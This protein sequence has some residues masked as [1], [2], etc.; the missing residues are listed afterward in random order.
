ML[1]NKITLIISL[2]I[3]IPFYMYSQNLRSIKGYIKNEKGNPIA[4][5]SVNAKKAG[6]I[7]ISDNN[8]NF[9]IDV[10]PTDSILFTHI[11]YIP[12]TLTVS[13]N[14]PSIL[15]IK[16]QEKVTGLE[17]VIINTG[18]QSI[19]KDRA[20]GSFYNIDNKI[21]N[22]QVTTNILDHLDGI[23][24]G[25]LVDKRNIGNDG[26]RYQ[27]RGLSTLT[28][29]IQSPLIVL[30]NFP[31]EG[32]LKN[33]NPND[34]ESVTILKDAAAS[35]IWGAR[36]GNGVIVITTKK[37]RK[38]APLQIS[39]N[40]NITIVSKPNLLNAPQIPVKDFIGL[41]EY[42]YNQEFYDWRF[43]D[44]WRTPLPAVAEILNLKKLALISENAADRQLDSLTDNDVRRDMEQYLYRNEVRSQTA[45]NLRGGEGNMR[46]LFSAGYD[47]NLYTLRGNRDER[48]TFRTDNTLDITKK[49]QLNTGII[50]TRSESKTNSP[51]GYGG[52]LGSAEMIAPYSRLANETGKPMA[53]DLYYRGL[54]TDTAGEGKL[55][56]WKYRPLQQLALNDISSK[57]SDI[58]I[59]IGSDYKIA[60]WLIVNIKYQYQQSNQK[61]PWYSSVNDFYTRDLINTFTQI[62]DN[63]ISY[64][65]PV[66]GTL[67]TIED[68][69][70]AQSVRGQL[71]FLH[72]WKNK[73]EVSAI[74]G[75][76][77]RSSKTDHAAGTI[78]GVNSQTLTTQG[79]D[80]VNP[81]YTYNGI[82]DESYIP[83]GTQLNKYNSRFVS[84]YGNASY[85][86]NNR[87]SLYGS[88][89]RDA[90]NIFGVSI[91]QK[92]Q[93]LWAV[94]GLWNLSKER[95][96]KA[97][98]FPIVNLRLSY[99][100]S[101]NLDPTTSALLQI[102]YIDPSSSLYRLQSARI[103]SPQN[104]LLRWEK[105]KTLNTGIDFS[106]KNNRLSGS[107]EYYK[108]HSIDLVSTVTLDPTTGFTYMRLNSA[109][110]KGNGVDI[111]LNSVNI[112]KSIKWNTTLLFSYT[113]FIV[114]NY[115][116]D[117]DESQLVTKGGLFPI[118]GYNP[119]SIIAY[120][121]AGLNP[122]SGDPQGYVD[123][124]VSSDYRI[125]LASD[126][127][128][129]V[130]YKTA[131]PPYYGSLRNIVE[132]KGFTLTFNISYKLGH[133]LL[134]P[135]LNYTTLF[136]S[137]NGAD[138]NSE[139]LNRWQ[140]RGDE[141]KTH[142]P[143]LI[144]PANS[145]RDNFYNGSSVNVINAG[146]IRLQ[147]I[148]LSY[149]YVP[150]RRQAFTSGQL[151]LFANQLNCL[152]WKANKEGLDP[153]ML[154]GIKPSINIS[155]GV[156]LNF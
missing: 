74:G 152:L 135:S 109:S 95:F 43:D 123:G 30:D 16:M 9:E 90:S 18:Y 104:D 38:N 84:I 68:T 44:V 100:L 153:E 139:Y 73:H 72:L 128:N 82:R 29:A 57:V 145:M 13:L 112:N 89:R 136:S 28:D 27:I 6:I 144:Y 4:G 132:W 80:L 88:A 33:I 149:D 34:V 133:Y 81:Y 86:Y 97:D 66:G 119:Y 113:N 39:V 99:G 71:S 59:N 49:W 146:Q 69:K 155:M 31:Y 78:Y 76:E 35:S 79:V 45:I 54:F 147:D 127:D 22:Q 122:E 48:F 120:K 108:K 65:A 5:V 46:Y 24:S 56:D 47:K 124:A 93:P 11:G 62:N 41:Q 143:S 26:P 141:I 63:N 92:W 19:S 83:D 25:L 52:Y 111:V 70:I 94:G 21:L 129:K 58:L 103:T 17:E 15:N 87:Y 137:G 12:Y 77:I 10:A 3:A 131:S 42:L 1:M 67:Y 115:S 64:A 20:T 134:K 98:W 138:G 14:T 151:Y 36:A 148:F 23:T 140:Q 55:L 32:D 8:G 85:T 130:I 117:I 156:K 7:N 96:Y 121:W 154:Y 61:S 40:S 75:G 50:F 60:H 106:L 107:I 116:Y 118:A 37:S 114:E 105:V 110:L 125:I 126:L 101:G 142:V 2:F 51:G 91:N 102:R 53:V 150:K